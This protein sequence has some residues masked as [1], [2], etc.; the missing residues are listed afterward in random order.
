VISHDFSREVHKISHRQG[1]VQVDGNLFHIP[2][3]FTLT[4]SLWFR[5]VSRYQ[6]GILA[7]TYVSAD[8]NSKSLKRSLTK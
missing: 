3:D 8:L 4:L 1:Y 5:M 7:K 6:I 2:S